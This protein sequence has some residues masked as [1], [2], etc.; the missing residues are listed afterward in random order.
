MRRTLPGLL[1]LAVAVAVAVVGAFAMPAGAAAHVNRFVGPYSILLFLVEEPTYQDNHAGFEFWVR[2]GDTPIV[3][4]E[5]STQALASGHGSVVALDVPPLGPDGFYVL[6]HAT[7]GSAFD[8][9]GGGAWTLTLT[10]SIEGTPL[11]AT[12]PVTFPSYPRIGNPAPA[13]ARVGAPAT[14]PPASPAPL[15][16]GLG[17]IGVAIGLVV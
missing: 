3:G 7:D 11:V 16:A 15:L 1:L 5:R 12:F 8:P 6:D 10:G 2:R 9:L 4:L 14:E 13:D 17:S